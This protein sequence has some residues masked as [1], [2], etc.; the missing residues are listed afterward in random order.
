METRRSG[1]PARTSLTSQTLWPSADILAWATPSVDSPGAG[2][3]HQT[4]SPSVSKM[5][6]ISAF[7]PFQNEVTKKPLASLAA[8]LNEKL[9][10]RPAVFCAPVASRWS[11]L[12]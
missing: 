3:Y 9:V 6:G 8:S 7:V 2:S 11:S 1:A 5:K 12:A 10:I 4:T